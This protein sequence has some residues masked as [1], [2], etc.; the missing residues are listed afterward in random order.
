MKVVFTLV[1]FI[2]AV[3]TAQST[4][5][6]YIT[7]PIQGTN[8]TAGDSAEIDWS[9]GSDQ[10]IT[11]SLLN[12]P[13]AQTQSVL[14]VIASNVNGDDGSYTWN[15][16]SSV[17]VS[18]TYSIRIEYGSG[19]YSYSAAFSID[20]GSKTL[21]YSAL[22]STAVSSISS[23]APSSVMLSTASS[24]VSTI[25]T[26]ASASASASASSGKPSA[27][28]STSGSMQNLAPVW[29]AVVPIIASLFF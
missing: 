20:G 23:A 17:G 9:N 10:K 29:A 28:A 22:P 2:A 1:A 16:P 7:A 27:S 8:F 15:I 21:S 4:A 6:Y 19:N 25:M 18:S 26:S 5:P 13:S 12:G 24:A 11:I 3:V 14:S